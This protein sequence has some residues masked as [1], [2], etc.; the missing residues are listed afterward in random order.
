M[1]LHF[2]WDETK[3]E[4]N[5]HKHGVSFLHAIEAFRDAHHFIAE[6]KKHR[7]ASEKRYFCIGEVDGRIMTVRFTLRENRIRIFGAAYWSKGKKIYATRN[8]L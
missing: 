6:D 4:A 2:E 1:L 8:R 7:S 3:N 5:T